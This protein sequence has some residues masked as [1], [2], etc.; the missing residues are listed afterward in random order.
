MSRNNKDTKASAITKEKQAPLQA[1]VEPEEKQDIESDKLSVKDEFELREQRLK[2][3]YKILYVAAAL[4]GG[5]ILSLSAIKFTDEIIPF[6]AFLLSITSVSIIR[7]IKYVLLE[8][9]CMNITK[10]D[11]GRLKDEAEQNYDNVWSLFGVSLA[12]L[13][14]L[15][16]NSIN[17]K[18]YMNLKVMTVI[19]TIC[20]GIYA[21]MQIIELIVTLRKK[22]ITGKG[23]IAFDI[24]G[25]LNGNLTAYTVYT[26]CLM[27]VISNA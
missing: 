9:R 11:N 19:F 7:I 2:L 14:I 16:W 5:L 8:L 26:I 21:V 1:V 23:K 24:I 10:T 3:V 15:L 4:W 13:G 12:F 22:P 27:A 6:Y 17:L 25:M 20:I 18:D